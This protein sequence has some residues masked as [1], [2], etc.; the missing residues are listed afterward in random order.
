MFGL[1]NAK[2]NKRS[3]LKRRCMLLTA[4][5]LSAAVLL[6]FSGCDD[7][8]AD[9]DEREQLIQELY[10]SVELAGADGTEENDATTSNFTLPYSRAD[11]I[12][13]YTCTS[14]LNATLSDLIYDQLVKV[15]S[16]FEAEMAIA[17]KIENNGAKNLVVTLRDGIVFSDGTELTGQDIV[18]SF[19]AAKDAKSRFSR[20]LANF[21]SCSSSDNLVYI[22]LS[23]AD[24]RAS[25]LL[26]FPIIKAE[27]DKEG[28]VPIGSGRYVYVNDLEKGTFLLRNEMWYSNNESNVVRV[29]L[30]SM[31]TVESIVHSVEI[32]TI[33][34]FYTDLRDG[35]PSRINA[36][37][38]TVDINN[39]IYVGVNTTN[40]SLT[41]Y[42]VRDA[43]SKAL[44]RE[45]IITSAYAG[46]AYAATGP[47]TT[48][49]PTAAAAQ[50]GS[51]LSELPGAIAELEDA[52]FINQDADYIRN[53]SAGNSLRYT[54]LVNEDSEQQCT[55]AERIA[56]QLEKAGIGVTIQPLAFNVLRQR[57]A[58][59]EYDLYIAEYSLFNNMDFSE[60][61]TP[62][63]GLY[64]G[65]IPQNTIDT[66]KSYLEGG[67]TIEG[68]I[69]AFESE[70]PFIPICYRLGM[71][72][73]SRSLSAN[74][75]VTESDLFMDMELW[76]VALAGN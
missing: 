60:I 48:S 17:L 11:S 40:P 20:Q 70:L 61:F 33:S 75:D 54:V 58:A 31:P 51:T 46:R 32:G 56:S 6:P 68:V 47:L 13:P 66:W 12:N 5:L 41:Q 10:G 39:L 49:W 15:N 69:E 65:L 2:P 21:L 3:A 45:E 62:N 67:A 23:N 72:C 53:D 57:I 42:E 73:Y 35:Y 37:Y 50:S 1:N 19:N 4:V 18:Y 16:E 38:S 28:K 36:K 9:Y 76:D 34:Y 59:G 71:V 26:D 74:M 27:S 63:K 25:L 55:V 52:G 64:Y 30:S 29:S 43:L 22:R 14:T 8:G 7:T 24:P 44:D